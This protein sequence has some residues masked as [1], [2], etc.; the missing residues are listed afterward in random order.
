MCF[1]QVLL[2]CKEMLG[3]LGENFWCSKELFVCLGDMLKQPDRLKLVVRYPGEML[4]YSNTMGK[5][6]VI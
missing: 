6:S 5:F 1:R 2:C 4:I 3:C